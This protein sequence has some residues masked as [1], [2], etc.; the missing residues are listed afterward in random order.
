MKTVYITSIMVVFA[1]IWLAPN[2][3]RANQSEDEAAIRKS[4]DAYVEAYN[5]QDAKALKRFRRSPTVSK[6]YH[7]SS[8]CGLET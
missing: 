6:S 5:K 7:Q 3:S 1:A 2:N 4:D 8:Y